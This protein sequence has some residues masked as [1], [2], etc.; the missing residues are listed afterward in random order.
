MEASAACYLVPFCSKLPNVLAAGPHSSQCAGMAPGHLWPAGEQVRPFSVPGTPE[1]TDKLPRSPLF[2]AYFSC[3]HHFPW[4]CPCGLRGNISVATAPCRGR[5]ARAWRKSGPGG[6]PQRS[7]PSPG[8]WP[9]GPRCPSRW[10]TPRT[11]GLLPRRSLTE[12]TSHLRFLL[13]HESRVSFAPEG[14]CVSGCFKKGSRTWRWHNPFFLCFC[15]SFNFF[16]NGFLS[17]DFN[18]KKTFNHGPD[19][20]F[21]FPRDQTF[22]LFALFFIKK[23][24]TSC[25]F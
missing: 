4:L 2:L 17:F 24:A 25:I 3:A 1:M 16:I 22:C 23:T 14:F 6:W 5:C 20:S 19:F 11:G 15:C 18:L 9:R 21:F 8:R 12:T 13:F 10:P 7:R